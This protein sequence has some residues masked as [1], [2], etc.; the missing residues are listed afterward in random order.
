[1]SSVDSILIVCVSNT[2]RF[3]TAEQLLKRELPQKTISSVGIAALVGNAADA[4]AAEVTLQHICFAKG[5]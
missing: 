4:T 3:P 5:A 2:C 1:M